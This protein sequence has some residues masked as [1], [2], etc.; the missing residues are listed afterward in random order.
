M[1]RV[2]HSPPPL[3]GFNSAGE[4]VDVA[5]DE[6]A[7]NTG[8]VELIAP[9][10]SDSVDNYRLRSRTVRPPPSLRSRRNTISADRRPEPSPNRGRVRAALERVRRLEYLGGEATSQNSRESLS[11]DSTAQDLLDPLAH[12]R[13]WST[14]T[15][16][17][18]FDVT[19]TKSESDSE[20]MA[21]TRLEISARDLRDAGPSGLNEDMRAPPGNRN[22]VGASTDTLSLVS[23]D[24]VVPRKIPTPAKRTSRPNTP[25]VP[26][27]QTRP[28]TP[29]FEDRAV[30]PP[31]VSPRRLLL[32]RAG[33]PVVDLWTQRVDRI[34][35]DAEDRVLLYR[36]VRIAQSETA[37]FRATAE[38]ISA[39]LRDCFP[40]CNPVK[41]QELATCRRAIS[42]VLV[43]LAEVNHDAELDASS[44]SSITS[45]PS[46][47]STPLDH[48]LRVFN[49]LENQQQQAGGPRPRVHSGGREEERPTAPGPPPA[50]HNSQAFV[51]AR[52]RNR[53]NERD[54][55]RGQQPMGD[56]LRPPQPP[57]GHQP[58]AGHNQQPG[59]RNNS[60]NRA[61]DTNGDNRSRRRSNSGSRDRRERRRGYDR[62][63]SP[64]TT[65]L[66]LERQNVLFLLGLIREETLEDVG[67]RA[68]L[69]SDVLK[70]LHDV[71]IPEVKNAIRDCRDAAGKYAARRDCD[72]R[73]VRRAQTAWENAY[74]WTRRVI[75]RYRGDQYHLGGNTPSRKITFTTFDPH[76]DVSVYEFFMRFEEWS[77]GYLSAEAKADLLFAEYLPKSLTDSYEELKVRRRDY[78]A[79]RAWLIDQ[80]GMIKMVCDAKIKLVKSLKPPKND[81]DLMGQTLYYRKIHQAVASLREL[82]IRKGICVPG[83]QQHMES[84]TF[85]MQVAEVLPKPIQLKWSEMLVNEGVTTWKVEGPEY[86]EKLLSVIQKAYFTAEVQ[87]RIPGNEH[88]PRPKAKVNQ[89]AR[90][91]SYSPNRSPSPTLPAAAAADNKAQGKRPT[92]QG[93]DGAKGNKQGKNAG[94][95]QGPKVHRWSCLIQG[96]EG[97]KLWECR[98]FFQL[99]T[100]ERREKCSQQGCWTCLAR[101]NEKGDCKRQECSRLKEVP[102]ALICQACAV[103]LMDGR[104]PLSI[105]FCGLEKHCKPSPEVVGEALEKWI[106]NFKVSGL[107]APLIIGLSTV[108]ATP[109]RMAPA[110]KTT[111]PTSRVP[112]Q[113]Y[114]TRDG[115]THPIQPQN[116]IVAPSKE[117]PFFIMQQLRIAGEDVLT[118]YDSGANIH[119]VEGSLAERVGFTVLDDRCVSIG[120]VGGGQ[121][122]TEYG[123]YACILGPDANLQYH[124]VE[125]QGLD[126]I[127]SFVP[128]VDLQPLAK[129]ASPTFYNGDQ[130]RYP[131]TVG[132]DRVKLLLGIRSTALAPRLHYALPNGLGVYVSALLDINGSNVCFGGTHEVFTQGFAKAGM[133]AGHVQVLFTQVATAYMGA[134]YSGVRLACEDHG[135]AKRPPLAALD[136]DQ[137]S[138][139]LTGVLRELGVS[140]P[141]PSAPVPCHCRDL[142]QC[143]YDGRCYKAAI[144]LSKL[145]GLLDEDDIPVIK[146]ARCDKC[147]NCPTCKLSSR[148]KT[149][150]L[151]EAFEQ[152]VIENSVTVDLENRMVRVELPFIKQSVEFLTK[153]HKGSDNLYQAKTIY[154]SQCRKPDEVKVQIRAAHQ[155]LMDK[156]FMTPLLSLPDKIQRRIQEAPFRHYYPWRAVYKP[157]SVS[158]PCRLVVDP[159]CTGLNI[160]LAK[161]ENM[162]AQIPDILIRLRIQRSAWTTDI[163][164]LY[165]RLYLEESALPYSLFLYD[166]SL[167]DGVK[168]EVYVMTRA[169]YGVSSTGNQAAVALRRLACL[170]SEESPLAYEMLTDN[171]YVDDVVGGADSET[172]REEQILQT[173]R[174]LNAGG[175]SPKF[176]A[177]SGIAPP[178]GSSSDGRTVGCL[179]LSWDTAQDKLSPSI[180][181][182]NLQ[183]KV[184]GQKAAP[185][186]D[187]TTGEGLRTAFKD[188]LITRAGVLSRM[189]EFFDPVGWWEP[190]RLQMKLSFQE[191]NAL[192]WKDPVPESA[193]ETW[194]GHFKQLE[195][196]QHLT[197]PRCVVPPSARP[198]WKIR[199]ICLADA[200]E[201]AGGAAIYG[202]IEK[203]D[204]TFTCNLLFSKSR[205]MRHTVPRNEL[206]AIVL[207][208]DTALV[209]QQS[210]GDRVSDVLFYTDSRVAQCWVLNTRKRLRMFVHNRAQA[211]RHGIRR[212]VDS[213]EILPLYH[214]EGTENLADMITKPR[215]LTALDLSPTSQWMTGLEWMT[216]PTDSLPRS[217]FLVPEDPT[218]E[219]QVSLEVFPDVENYLLQ[220]EYRESLTVLGTDILGDG[221]DF[222]HLS[223]PPEPLPLSKPPDPDGIVTIDYPQQPTDEQSGKHEALPVLFGRA[224]GGGRLAWLEENF[225]FLHFGW[226]RALSRLSSVIQITQRFRHVVHRDAD[227]PEEGCA[228]CSG[229][230]KQTAMATA[231]RY[232]T[233]V[234]SA[235]AQAALGK[236]KLRR[237]CTMRGGVWYASQ[238]LGKEGLLDVADLDF[239]AFYDGVSI[240]KVLPVMLVDTELFRALALHIHFREFPHQGVEATLARLK[241]TFYPLGY[242][243]R[244]I[245]SIRKSC[246]KCRILLKQVIGLELAD[247]HPMRST[248]APPF[249]AVQMDIAMGF[250]ARPT[251]DSRKSFTAHALVIVCLLTSATSIAVLDGLTTQTVVM[252]LERHASRYG[253]PAHIFVDSG[254]QLEKLGDTHFSLRDVNGWESQ[255]KRFTVKVSTPKAH[256]QQGRVESKIKVVRKLLQSLSDTAELV[257]TLL[258]WETTFLRIADQIDDLPMARGSDRAPTDLGWEIITPNRLKLGRNNFRQLEGTIILSNAPQT[259]LERNRLCQERW[260]D[261]FI[262][263]IHLLVPKA[264]RVDAL[265]LQPDDVVLFVFQDA[266]VHRM[267]VWRLG[268]IVRQ[269]SRTTYEIRYIS[270]PGGPPRLITRDARHI[271]LVHKTDEIPPM[272]TRFLGN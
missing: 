224:Q 181:S 231:I 30:I 214:I 255:G 219:E 190:L 8:D 263:R 66:E 107:G 202:G 209:V 240:K 204:G 71:R 47:R 112:K 96:H 87:A 137:W 191:L 203:P 237:Q 246:S 200:G 207:A 216:L 217:Q 228:V 32:E 75:A 212:L 147:A 128:E 31:V 148:A 69:S 261:L 35:M 99:T 17:T 122:W 168:P 155:E 6:P 164:K 59:G 106:P 270:T 227:E 266:G 116:D 166:S 247:L 189:A 20:E 159:S 175:F 113:T 194:V 179:G 49:N 101:R 27:R 236:L 184:R 88:V 90:D 60:G 91:G 73:L 188:G 89:A 234:A 74:D 119:L 242:A 131:K 210:L 14:S 241:Q 76:G 10:V 68:L 139:E 162:L 19:V 103:N 108:L 254:T 123:Q 208:A 86:L 252:A 41:Q 48:Y 222:P 84:N 63:Y 244:M 44:R 256:E 136:V 15:T 82:E 201:G 18:H 177:R 145:K 52:P 118:F 206:E 238:R 167:S 79:M 62:S 81:D 257:N 138:E 36:G 78:H 193:V 173:K 25:V 72:A 9:A 55:H 223:D 105:F 140:T 43:H 158:T 259:Q 154:K 153:R 150:S 183:R 53:S 157:G 187:V 180:A 64:P 235:Q 114:D 269:V 160:I 1:V 23:T 265:V 100:K 40:N 127:T 143:E 232:I 176:M 163:S 197:I 57:T 95:P 239:E 39:Q 258:G 165:N 271:C 126:R 218:E 262:E 120:V 172:A 146:D 37:T 26:D 272:S 58:A 117:Q 268:V 11:W 3:R 250:K 213:E 93:K 229:R 251:N 174:V 156:G 267:W 260:Y 124:Q 243:R 7:A 171:I 125:C 54:N 12:Q 94:G 102:V 70:E 133:S 29:L 134:P 186:R 198:D 13:L 34:L 178:D 253:M 56:G 129:E 152:E 195:E 233:L 135:P 38:L 46:G 121:V 185:D 104:P 85:L 220:L 77:K 221:W 24:T 264:E 80:Y 67:P 21:S 170:N 211:A 151:Q 161:G 65:A 97:H 245:A 111:P 28:G 192:D 132:G 109:R 249:Y 115:T 45:E 169:W 83:L 4:P 141:I 16:S 22:D 225:D 142:G 98:E 51:G 61:E 50:T 42:E 2:E 144:P 199:L 248:I 33:Q 182:M 230:E 130:L 92:S 149:Q 215:K 196:A 110:S 205:L 226:A 5:S